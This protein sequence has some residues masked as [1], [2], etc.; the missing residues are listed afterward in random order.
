MNRASGFFFQ[1][2][3][4]QMAHF[5]RSNATHHTPADMMTKSRAPAGGNNYPENGLVT[6]ETAET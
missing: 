5:L 4:L 1:F 6:F 3:K 2:F